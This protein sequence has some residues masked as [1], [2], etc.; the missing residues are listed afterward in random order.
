MCSWVGEES[1][2]Y[3]YE[4][5]LDGNYLRKVHLQPVPQW[6]QGVFYYD[7]SLF[8]T[9][10]DGTADD[11]E[12]DHLYRVDISSASYAPVILEKTFTETI[13]QGEIE[14]LCVDPSTGDLLVHQNRGARIVLGMTKGMYPGYKSEVHEIYRY[15]LTPNK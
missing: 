2:R 10:D 5:D 15:K 1:G 8:L 6:V 3:L 4:Y 12:P 14:G 9:A 13:R 7:G 11:N